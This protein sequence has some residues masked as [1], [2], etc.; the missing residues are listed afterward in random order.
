M[1]KL[2]SMENL[3]LEYEIAADDQLAKWADEV[4]EKVNSMQTSKKAWMKFAMGMEKTIKVNCDMC[5]LTN[6]I[7]IPG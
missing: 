4:T 7:C 1:K 3:Q 6:C 2:E 5:G